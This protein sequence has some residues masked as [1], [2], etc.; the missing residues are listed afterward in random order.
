MKRLIF[1]I[2]ALLWV[3]C[4]IAHAAIQQDFTLTVLKDSNPVREFNG[5]VAIPFDTEY[6]LRLKNG[7]HRRCSATVWIDGAKVSEMGNF[8]IDGNDLLDLERFLDRSLTEGKRFKFVPLDHPDVDDPTRAE[9]GNIKVEFRLEKLAKIMPKDWYYK[10]LRSPFTLELEWEPTIDMSEV[11]LYVDD[12]SL[13]ITNGTTST[14]VNILSFNHDLLINTGMSTTTLC[15]STS[16]G[17]TIPGSH[18]NQSFYKVDFDGEDEVV[19]VELRM[20]GI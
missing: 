1:I 16:A 14:T 3:S 2:I 12:G 13:T 6:K 15:S 19:V 11:D 9:N 4:G 7:N 17:A 8:I 10:D 20:V 18:S 5:E